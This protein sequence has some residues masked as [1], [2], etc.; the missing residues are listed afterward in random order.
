[1]KEERRREQADLIS[2]VMITLLPEEIR[3]IIAIEQNATAY[4]DADLSVHS[5]AQIFARLLHK[6][7][8]VA[9]IRHRTPDSGGMGSISLKLWRDELTSSD[10]IISSGG[11]K[12]A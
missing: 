10:D 3:Y 1:M 6:S 5:M 11:D 7:I 4:I 8:P 9:A 2:N 12:D